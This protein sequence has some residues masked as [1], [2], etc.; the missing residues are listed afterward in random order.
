MG[1]QYDG[2]RPAS[3]ST[4]EIDFYYAGQRCRERIKLQPTPANLKRAAN[5]RAAV[6]DAIARGA[7]D[8]G[9]TFPHSKNAAKFTRKKSAGT[10]GAYLESW[11]DSKAKTIKASSADGYR[12]AI[13]GRLVPSLG[14]I[15][16][17]DLRRHQ[18]KAMCEGMD[19]TNKRIANVLSVLRTAL[20]DAVTDELIDTNPIAGW[21]YARN[22]APKE[23][24]DIDPF[25]ADEQAR[26]LEHLDGQGRNLVQ[27]AFWT[28]L[29]TSELVALQWADVDLVRGEVRI[30]RATTQAAK[31]AAEVPKTTSSKRTV[32]LL[33]GARAA[34]EAQRSHTQTAGAHV[35]HNPRTGEPWEGD[36]PIRKTLWQP[37]LQRAKVR[38]RYPYQTRHTYASMMLTA[39]ENPMWV[40]KQMGHADWGMIR[41][42]Y[43]RFMPEAVP[44]AGAKAEALFGGGDG[45][46][47]VNISPKTRMNAG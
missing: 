28:G 24:D 21:T 4:I 29:R 44:D 1:K 11:I 37:A 39:G 14:A 12:K 10:V 38:Y 34:L 5:H 31:G 27:F 41:R 2:V 6:L 13:N 26:I 17:A 30:R 19:V 33:A 43:G 20:D 40:A 25:T 32:K 45:Q 47:L 18:V 36:G 46:P 42:I 16:L 15:P 22:E 7:F 9:V 35:F 23:E 3:E 8:Y